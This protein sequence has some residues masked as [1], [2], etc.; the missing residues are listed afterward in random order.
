MSPSAF[1]FDDIKSAL[2]KVFN[3]NLKNSDSKPVIGWPM[4]KRIQNKNQ[5]YL[6]IESLFSQNILEFYEVGYSLARIAANCIVCQV[7]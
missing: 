2:Q 1:V 4:E 5:P 6:I 3:S 7:P